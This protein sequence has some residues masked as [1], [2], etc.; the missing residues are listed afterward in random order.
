MD[1]TC[2]CLIGLFYHYWYYVVNYDVH[3]PKRK[4]PS[5]TTFHPGEVND[6]PG[7]EGIALSSSKST[8]TTHGLHQ[9][10]LLW[11]FVSLIIHVGRSYEMYAIHAVLVNYAQSFSHWLCVLFAYF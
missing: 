9:C 3:Y 5:N 1:S 11:Q 2:K 7:M 10:E 4:Y 6:G 8:E